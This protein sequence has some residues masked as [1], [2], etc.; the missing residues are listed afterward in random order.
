MVAGHSILV[1]ILKPRKSR[2]LMISP[3]TWFSWSGKRCFLTNLHEDWVM[4]QKCVFCCLLLRKAKE[5]D[6]SLLQ[7]IPGTFLQHILNLYC[8]L[9]ASHCDPNTVV[10]LSPT[11]K[12]FGGYARATL[13]FGISFNNLLFLKT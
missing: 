5:D 4:W 13:G 3:I 9:S 2:L 12:S 8:N 1:S 7:H 11:L 10:L 6:F